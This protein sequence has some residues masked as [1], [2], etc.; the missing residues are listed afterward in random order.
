MRARSSRWDAAIVNSHRIAVAVDILLGGVTI[1]EGLAVQSGRVELDRTA[2]ILGRCDISLAEPTRIPSSSGGELSPFG[3]EA[4]VRRG[5]VYPDGSTELQSLGV[6]PIQRSATDGVSLL[7]QITA[8]DRA[9]RVKDARLEDDYQIAAGTNYATAIHDLIDAGVPGLTYAFATTTFTTPL[10]T[11][12]AQSDRWDAARGM[13]KAIGCELYF[14]GDGVCKMRLEP[15][16]SAAPVWT[17]A[18]GAGGVLLGAA[19]SLDRAGAYNRV[20][21]TGENATLGTVP[22]GVATDDDPASPT[23]YF[24][25]F[26]KK[27]RFYKS[28]FMATDAQCTTAADSILRANLGVASAVSFSA[29][30]NEALEAGDPVQIR[31]AA[32]GV[33]EVH[34]FDVLRFE[35]GPDGDMSGQS[36]A[37]Q[38]DPGA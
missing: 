20:V 30:P 17:V 38:L 27:P 6:F 35:L 21:A 4:R 36:R 10:L 34:L 25:T 7:T 1:T 12:A 32:L 16:A 37:S 14:D 13:A 2:A 33:D 29:V 15:S 28:P 23:Y 5:I 18:E 3:Y 22:R 31:R 9:Q 8:F 11:F 19:L 26:G 24:G